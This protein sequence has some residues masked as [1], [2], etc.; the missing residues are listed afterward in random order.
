MVVNTKRFDDLD[1]GID[2]QHDEYESGDCQ[3]PHESH[4]QRSLP[5][6]GHNLTV[7]KIESLEPVVCSTPFVGIQIESV[8]P[9]RICHMLKQCDK[10]N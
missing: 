3:G 8:N 4:G 9:A 1:S 5:P 2:A 7:S 6:N 10:K